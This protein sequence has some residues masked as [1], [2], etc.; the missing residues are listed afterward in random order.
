MRIYHINF[1]VLM[2]VLNSFAIMIACSV[3]FNICYA[4]ENSEWNDYLQDSTQINSPIEYIDSYNKYTVLN[5]NLKIKLVDFG[6]IN[7]IKK[8]IK[9]SLKKYG[10]QILNRKRDSLM[11]L[12]GS[13]MCI[14]DRLYNDK[15]IVAFRIRENSNIDY[16]KEP[17]KNFT[18]N[19]YFYN[20]I[21]NKFIEVPVLN[22]DSEDKS[23]STDIL[24][25]DQL[26][27]D[28]KKGQYIY[29]AN[30]KSYK[31]GKTQSIKTIFNSNLKCISSTLGC[32][33]I[34]VLPATKAN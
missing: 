6:N 30:I 31:T 4:K 26:T 24:Q 32:E 15:N 9:Y 17:Y 5:P 20:L 16:V 22:S 12:V 19:A 27:Y 1:E 23:K 14:R 13:E 7:K 11:C 18:A 33:T 29:L 10:V 28:S 21:N 25:G 8:D 34:G 2:K 3:S